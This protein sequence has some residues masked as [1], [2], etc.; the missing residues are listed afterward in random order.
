MNPLQTILFL[1][2]VLPVVMIKKLFGMLT[3][4]MTKEE[5]KKL[6]WYIPYLLIF[7]LVVLMIIL[8]SAG[9]R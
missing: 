1:I 5:K 8:W 6:L 2:F 3:K 7:L 9:L 4:D